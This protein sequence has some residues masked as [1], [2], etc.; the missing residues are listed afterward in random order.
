MKAFLHLKIYN[1][2]KDFNQMTLPPNRLISLII[3]KI[4]CLLLINYL[5]ALKIILINIKIKFI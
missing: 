4:I 1:V 3:L 2:E 5:I